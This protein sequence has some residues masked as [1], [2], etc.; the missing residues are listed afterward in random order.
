MLVW[1][2]AWLLELARAG[3]ES[4]LCHLPAQGLWHAIPLGL[5][6]LCAGDKDGG[7][8]RDVGGDGW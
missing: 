7:V 1:T 8:S 2:G 3:C 6:V 5:S 4:R